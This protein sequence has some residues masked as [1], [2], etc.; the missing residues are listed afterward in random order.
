VRV[1]KEI[2]HESGD[3]HE[4][5]RR[6]PPAQQRQHDRNY[7]RQDYEGQSFFDH[8]RNHKSYRKKPGVG[9]AGR[10]EKGGCIK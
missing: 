1:P 3:E 8:K 6:Q 10:K 9:I 4:Y 7:K 2:H 5:P